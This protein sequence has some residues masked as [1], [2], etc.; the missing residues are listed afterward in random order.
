MNISKLLKHWIFL[1]EDHRDDLLD[2]LPHDNTNPWFV[3]ADLV[4]SE[5]YDGIGS[6]CV[7]LISRHWISLLKQHRENLVVTLNEHH[8]HA[9]FFNSD[10]IIAQL[11]LAIIIAEKE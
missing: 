9:W 2:L 8:K 7:V 4:R 3:G 6:D 5:M 11:E 1:L 10:I